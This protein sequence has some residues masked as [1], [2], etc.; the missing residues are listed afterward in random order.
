MAKV[1]SFFLAA[2]SQNVATPNGGIAQQLTLPLIVLRPKFIPS[3]FSFSMALGINEINKNADS[4][5]RIELVSPSGKQVIDTGYIDLPELPDDPALPIEYQGFSLI[6]PVQNAVL[7]QEG[8]YHLKVYFNDDVV[9]FVQEIP[10]YVQGE[11]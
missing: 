7:D 11:S 8:V 5:M 2:N 1:V 10:V 6:M 4:R 3:E 9:I